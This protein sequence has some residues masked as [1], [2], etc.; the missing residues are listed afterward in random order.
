MLEMEQEEEVASE[1]V[2]SAE[3]QIGKRLHPVTPSKSGPSKKRQSRLSAARKLETEQE[4]EVVSE[5]VESTEEQI[6]KRSHPVTPTKS[7]P[8]KKRPSRLSAAKFLHMK[9]EEEKEETPENVG[10]VEDHSRAFVFSPPK[11]VATNLQAVLEEMESVPEFALSPPELISHPPMLTSQRRSFPASRRSARSLGPIPEVKDEEEQIPATP[12]P[13]RGR[14]S[15]AKLLIASKRRGKEKHEDAERGVSHGSRTSS[16]ELK[17]IEESKSEEDVSEKTKKISSSQRHRSSPTGS[18]VS[19]GALDIEDDSSL[20]AEEESNR[21][22]DDSDTLPRKPA[23]IVDLHKNCA[24]IGAF[25]LG[26]DVSTAN[27]S[28]FSAIFGGIKFYILERR[29]DSRLSFTLTYGVS[30][31]GNSAYHLVLQSYGSLSGT[32]TYYELKIYIPYTVARQRLSGGH[33]AVLH[34]RGA[35]EGLGGQQRVLQ[36]EG[37]DLGGLEGRQSYFMRC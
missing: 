6:G 27:C 22:K 24:C 19:E 1:N 2:E 7:G 9:Q 11:A 20:K 34:Q 26:L 10:S 35:D 31:P 3:E 17:P 30:S 23:V 5:N 29:E 16:S 13:R 12:S 18:V 32:R 8:S 28:R 14:P 36:C 21:T 33:W 37:A 15:K 25:T 4:E